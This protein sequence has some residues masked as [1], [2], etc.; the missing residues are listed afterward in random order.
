[1][2]L[3]LL[4]DYL[5]EQQE[6]TAVERFARRE[7]ASLV[8]DRVYREVMP[9]TPP[10][11]G[12][13]YAFRVDLDACTGCK[14]CVTACH[15]QNGLDEDETWRSV[16]L[17]RG[18]TAAAAVQQT[19]TSSCHH[20][21]DPACMNGCPVGAYEKDA[22]T[23]I[24]KH[25]D[26]QCIGC[27]YCTF[28]CPYEAPKYNAKRGIVR[29]CDMCS[30]RIAAGEPPA[31]VEACPTSAIA[32]TIVA[33]AQALEEAQ[34]DAF[35]PGAPSPGITVPTTTYES[36]KP[37]PRNTLPADFYRVRRSEHHVP[38]VVMLVLTQLSVGAFVVDALASRLVPEAVR[39][40]HE[41][42]HVLVAFAI[43]LVAL[44]ASVFHLGRPLYAFRAALGLR[45][46]WMSREIVA[47]GLFAPLAM[48]HAVCSWLRLDR[49][50]DV[51]GMLV[52]IV[53]ALAIACSVFIY[54]AT[55]RPFWTASLTAFRF[56]LTA[57]ILGLATG[58]VTFAAGD[59]R[60]FVVLLSR[61]VVMAS[62]TKALGELSIFQH[63]RDHRQHDLKRTAM[64]LRNDLASWTAARFVALVLGGIVLPIL[65]VHDP[66]SLPLSVASWILLL[67]GELC[68]RTLFF[69]ASSSRGMPGGVA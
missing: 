14:A 48:A 56:F 64:L 24:V 59:A 20:C 39:V 33:K 58:I 43:G 35:V 36:K 12:H 42:G 28:M 13:Q 23:G 2:R 9:L 55:K 60:D 3:P 4:Q 8:R 16:G 51:L 30:H 68:E 22:V 46:S 1:M 27:Q 69:A 54:D 53:G 52:A 18:G 40:R 21:L 45:T 34:N 50:H 19:I 17:L 38:L 37:L 5:R 65:Q 25:L 47:F 61:L 63:L 57:A 31:C 15:V 11:E 44:G 7:R 62:I 41:P 6:L 67:L 10:P 49:I 29:K 32:I 66:V 26:D